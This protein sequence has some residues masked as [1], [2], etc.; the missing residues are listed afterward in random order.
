MF[1]RRHAAIDGFIPGN[2]HVIRIDDSTRLRN[3]ECDMHRLEIFWKFLLLGCTSFGGPA[4]HVGYFRAMFVER[5]GWL[6]EETFGRLFALSQFLPGPGSSQLGFAIGCHRAGTLG[7]LA[8]FVGF[9]LPSFLIMFGLALAMG[10]GNE[11]MPA[12]VQGLLHGLKLLAVVVVADATLG[13]FRSFCKCRLT[14]GLC[15]ATAAA[16]LMHQGMFVQF[17]ALM[18]A[19][20]IGAGMLREKRNN[21]APRPEKIR[22]NWVPLIVFALLFVASPALLML[23]GW[24]NLFA[25]FYQAGSLVFGGG[26]VVLPLLQSHSVSA[27]LNEDQFLVGYAAAQAVPGPM[28]TLATFLGSEL[29]P[30]SA[31]RGASLATL[32]IFLPGFLLVLGLKDAWHALTTSPKLT[33]AVRGLNAGVVGL[34]LAACYQ[35]VFR[36]SVEVPL[37]FALVVVGF[38]LLRALKFPVFAL[39]AAF[40][41][42]GALLQLDLT[43]FLR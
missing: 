41:G 18:A 8:A 32:G 6:E 4:A 21:V 39:V 20:V 27:G 30:A 17:G 22:P 29:S 24:S 28:F 43:S 34:L 2:V 19:A 26:H 23:G 40:A 3:K 5:L 33:G 13:M 10:K 15:V 16:L 36:S 12:P 31:L 25:G 1:G 42:V 14:A 11:S 9:T 35:P 37:D 7:G 38:F